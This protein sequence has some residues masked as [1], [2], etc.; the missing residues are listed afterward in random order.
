[1]MARIDDKGPVYAIISS[2]E[3]WRDSLLYLLDAGIKLFQLRSKN[4]S[5]REILA[6]ACAMVRLCHDNDALL[7]VN[8]RFDIAYLAGADGVHLGNEDLPPKDVRRC[9]PG[10]VIG[11]TVRK[12][13]AAA[14]AAAA[15][16]DYLGVGPVYAS[17]NKPHLPVIGLDGL[18][19]VTEA[20]DLPVVAIGGI[21]PNRVS[22]VLACGATAAAMISGL[23]E[24]L[25]C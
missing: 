18:S 5:D 14:A 3:S 6:V 20:V 15:G 25:K 1:M 4:S 13:E 11:V 10:A 2:C 23:K 12:P 24:I 17:P 9:W 16:A 7:L 8:D 22:Q 21:T 19:M